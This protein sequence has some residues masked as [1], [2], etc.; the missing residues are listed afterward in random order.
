MAKTNLYTAAQRAKFDG[1]DQPT[2]AEWQEAMFD[3]QQAEHEKRDSF[4]RGFYVAPTVTLDAPGYK[5]DGTNIDAIL[6]GKRLTTAGSWDFSGLPSGTYHGMLSN[7]NGFVLA[8]ANDAAKL[9]LFTVAW[10]GETH[11]L[12]AF[13][14]D[15]I[16]P[17]DGGAGGAVTSVNGAGGAVVLDTDDI[18]EN[19]NSPVNLWHTNARVDA[20]ITAQKGAA[21]GIASLDGDGKVPLAQL[22]A[23]A[24][25]TGDVT[26][27]ASAIDGHLPAFDGVT[28]KLLKGSGLSMGSAQAAVNNA[29]QHANKTNLDAYT[30]D[31]FVPAAHTDTYDHSLMRDANKLVGKTISGSPAAGQVPTYDGENFIFSTPSA[32]ATGD[33]LKADYAALAIA[34]TVD[35]AAALNDG[36]GHTVTA[37]QAADAILGPFAQDAAT[38]S[39]LTFG[40]KAGLVQ[41]ADPHVAGASTV[42]AVDAGTILLTNNATNYVF[43]AKSNNVGSPFETPGIF[44][45]TSATVGYPVVYEGEYC[46]LLYKVVT[47]GGAITSVTDLRATL[48]AHSAGILS[49]LGLLNYVDGLADGD[50]LRVSTI[51]E[52]TLG[53]KNV[54]SHPRK[55]NY[56]ATTA[57]TVTDDAGDGYA[58]GSKWINVT[59]DK[60]YVC[61]DAT[62]N[63]AIWK[64]M[65]AGQP[66]RI[67]QMTL[68]GAADLT[69]DHVAYFDIPAEMNGWRLSGWLAKCTVASTSGAIKLPVTFNGTSMFS[70]PIT[71]DQ[72]ETSSATAATS[73]VIDTDNDNV[74]TGGTVAAGCSAA[75]AGVKY[76]RVTLIFSEA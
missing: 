8:L 26:G 11:A 56:T 76:A 12:T 19:P 24:P 59:L 47:A 66:K 14:P 2:A 72:N 33:M 73:A 75:G 6:D 68:N 20:R 51:G 52:S 28:G 31:L 55:N 34:N 45:V 41:A 32:S 65:L 7:T 5:V 61:V 49:L 44:K 69:T 42:V 13:T 63:A 43:W 23:I 57:P 3:L 21:N 58:V 22:P 37:E 54:N 48:T 29:H 67:V 53:W 46:C 64:E 50:V 62:T 70:T 15:T 30:P 17:G 40:Y 71:I 38:T 27:P 4:R 9:H 39:G 16:T 35:K 60:V 25:G 10:N 36:A 74:A 1:S 18:Q